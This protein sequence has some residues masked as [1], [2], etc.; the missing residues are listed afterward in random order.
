MPINSLKKGKNGEREFANFCKEHGFENRRG[1]QYSG[2]EG[3]DC[4][5]L[6]GIHQEV[7]R[8]EKLNIYNAMEQS[9]SDTQNQIKVRKLP[10]EKSLLPIV[11][12]RKNHKPWLVTMLAEDWF[13]LFKSWVEDPIN[14]FSDQGESD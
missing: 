11:A 8:V 7:K 4:V 10:Y 3:E 12:H 5:G 6:P 13:S 9:I 2:L 1:R 14:Q